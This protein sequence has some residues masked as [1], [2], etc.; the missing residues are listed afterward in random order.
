LSAVPI[1]TI[2][3]AENQNTARQPKCSVMKL[4]NGRASMMPASNPLMI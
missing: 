3:S 1:N 4:A 2:S